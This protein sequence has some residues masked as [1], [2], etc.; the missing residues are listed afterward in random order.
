MR[1]LFFKVLGGVLFF[2]VVMLLIAFNALMVWVAT[3]PRSLDS[4]LPYIEESLTPSDGKF[5][6]DIGRAVLMWDGWQHPLD[7]RLREVNV[8]TSDGVRFASF[9]DISLGLD[10]PSLA[11][12]R[13]E[14]ASLIVR[15]PVVSLYQASD[16]SIGFGTP[17]EPQTVDGGQET[18]QETSAQAV[19]DDTDHEE[20]LIAEAL[21]ALS[22]GEGIPGVDK[23]RRIQ[24]TDADV[25][26]GNTADGVVLRLSQVAIEVRRGKRRAALKASAKLAQQGKP[27]MMSLQARIVF[28]TGVSEAKVQLQDLQTASIAPLLKKWGDFSGIQLP[29][30]GWV[31]TQMDKSGALTLARYVLFSGAGT[32]QLPQLDGTIP[33]KTVQAEGSLHSLSDITLERFEA[34]LNGAVVR[35]NARIQMQNDDAAIQAKLLAAHVPVNYV[36]LFWPLGASPISREWVVNNI[37]EGTV[38]QASLDVNINFGDLQKPALPEQ[39]INAVVAFEKAS[40]S[41]LPQHEPVR[42]AYGVARING[43]TLLVEAHKASYLSDTHLKDGQVTIDDL[44][45][46]NPRIEVAFEADAAAADVVQFL[47]LPPADLATK[48]NLSKE[49]AQGRGTGKVK[50]GFYYFTPP[51]PDGKPRDDMG[52]DYEVAT[53]LQNVSHPAFMKRFD[54]TGANGEFAINNAELSFKGS[55]TVND[56]KA[57]AAEVRYLFAPKD[58]LDTFIVASATAPVASLKRFGL[59]EIPYISGA[60]GGDVDV[61]LGPG[62]EKA[63]LNLNLSGTELNVKQ[64]QYAKPAATPGQLSMQVEQRAG[65][66]LQIPAFD[67][68]SGETRALGKAELTQDNSDVQSASLSTLKHDGSDLALIY[69]KIPGGQSFNAKGSAM[70]LGK[71]LNGA[72][73]EPS[74]FSFKYFPA[75]ELDLDLGRVMFGESKELAAVKGTLNCNAD[76]CVHADLRGQA[77]GKPFS[78]AINAAGQSR[79]VEARAQDA[80]AF[81]NGMDL[82]N[83]MSG[84]ELLLSATFDDTKPNRPLTGTLDISEHMIEDAPVLAKLL[85]LASLTGFVDTL[86]GKG[87]MFKKLHAP[88]TLED[89]VITLKEAKTYGPA[90][91]ISAEGTVTFPQQTL[92]IKGT[93]VPSHTLNTMLG[94]VPIIGD[95]VTGGG[96]GVFGARYSMSGTFEN[97]DVSVNPL[98]I[99]TPGFLRG[100]FDV[101]DSPAESKKPHENAPASDAEEAPAAP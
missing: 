54:I 68:R 71:I 58:G 83:K 4:A 62:V 32:I 74:T 15:K 3:G 65:A 81:L 2:A 7:I 86:Q 96:E 41:F 77:G 16:G 5:R 73:G 42:D 50:L 59:P 55:G 93:V 26:V 20:V 78:F 17:D 92:N 31:D 30:S 57:S 6:V 80:G 18:Q 37:T 14:P 97:A 95:I 43:K 79:R 23:L 63:K 11:L 19:S 75:L 76:R 1:R 51:G 84:G 87:I 36:R 33:V 34:D 100:L 52:V 91:G 46:D 64:F 61:A 82:Y 10:L 66:G 27:A 94:G 35:G 67:Y 99:L 98:S 47:S 56:A 72:E 25:S 101:F 9:P 29:L 8:L 89:D 53:T 69:R 22:R 85:T 39:S 38:P 44:N 60:I 24:L 13:V 88:F 49:K 90:I 45:L 28:A 40:V 12:G 21:R 48:L 70:N